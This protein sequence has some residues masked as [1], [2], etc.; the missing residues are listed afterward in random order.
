MSP[1]ALPS[2]VSASTAR[3][4]R[5]TTGGAVW[6][7]TQDAITTFLDTGEIT[8][9]GLQGGLNNSG[10]SPEQVRAGLNKSYG[11]DLIALSNFLY[12]A[13]GETYLRNQTR[14]YVPY[15]TL[16][17]WAIQA[18]RSA[19]ILDAADASMSGA[20]IINHLPVDFRIDDSTPFDGNQNVSPLANCKDNAQCTSLLSWMVF[21]PME[22]S[23]KAPMR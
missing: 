6:S 17:T 12:S 14:S 16:N 22:L 7:T 23:Q 3:P 4:I 1:F 20:G 11:V 13:N 8:D 5:W 2:L 10:W 15:W 19:I 18:L 21:L 9:R